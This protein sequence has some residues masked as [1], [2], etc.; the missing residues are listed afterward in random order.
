MT[1]GGAK[2]ITSILA[3]FFNSGEGKRPLA[4]FQQELKALSAE[5]KHELALGVCAITGET[6][7]VDA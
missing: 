4:I 5:E 3:T 7:K 6:I 1:T 2:G